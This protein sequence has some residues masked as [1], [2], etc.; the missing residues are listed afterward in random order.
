M[1]NV[2]ASLLGSPDGVNGEADV[3]ATAVLGVRREEEVDSVKVLDLRHVGVHFPGFA[4]CHCR[5]WALRQFADFSE[6]EI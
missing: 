4:L 2:V 1:L 6:I 5:R 3:G